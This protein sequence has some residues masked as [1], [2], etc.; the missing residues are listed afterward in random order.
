LRIESALLARCAAVFLLLS[1]TGCKKADRV[2]AGLECFP[3]DAALW[4][5]GETQPS[6][7]EGR[8]DAGGPVTVYVDASG[9]MVGYLDGA[10]DSERPFHD[11]VATLPTMFASGGTTPVSFR[12]FGT[13]IREVGAGQHTQLV[14]R[15]YYSCANRSRADCDNQDTR[16]DL[17]FGEIQGQ[18]D[19]LS[20][21]V[22]DMWFSDPASV[23]TG[24]VPLAQPLEE[25]L[26]SGRSVA[27]YGIRAPFRG[28]I[29]DLPGGAT[30]PLSG[31][32]PLLVLAV[33][34]DD[35][36]RRFSE[37]LSRSPSSQ[38]ARGFSDGS[39]HQSVFT[40]NPAVGSTRSAEPLGSGEDP[41]VRQAQVFEAIEGV[42]VQQFRIDRTRANR[43]PEEPLPLPAWTGPD[44]QA[45]M[46]NA[47]WRGPLSTRL[48]VWNRS[49]Q[50]CVPEDWDEPTITSLGWSEAPGSARRFTLDPGAFV[51]EFRRPGTYLVTAQVARTSLNEPN[52]ANGWL[53]E[54]SFGAHQG[55]D[56]ARAENGRFFRTL[57]LAEFARLLENSLADAAERD[58]GPIIGFTFAVEVTD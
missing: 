11:L 17:V 26:A 39:V 21:I 1:A 25:I 56:A 3:K 19:Q 41:R 35:R 20:I 7:F 23:T 14:E 16:L 51:G 38:L 13:R 12:S 46:P 30:A 42:Q 18:P 40:L 47:V 28:N 53:R 57:H 29:Y 8:R 44:D 55:L 54:W 5:A 31:H 15:G 9:S 6:S 36:V 45:F 58:P 52:E 43:E 48:L 24:L 50:Q 32:R 37:Q 27:V 10:T 33:G 2:G 49:G 4:V 22:T 34:P